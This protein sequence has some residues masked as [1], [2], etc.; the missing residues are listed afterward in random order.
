[1]SYFN[2]NSDSFILKSGE[3]DFLAIVQENFSHYDVYKSIDENYPDPPN[4]P[5]RDGLFGSKEIQDALDSACGRLAY[6]K[7][8]YE[9]KKEMFFEFIYYFSIIVKEMGKHGYSVGNPHIPKG[10][11]DEYEVYEV[12]RI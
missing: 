5:I 10:L 8:T 2:I 1:M 3:Y 12:T 4:N 9:E 6:R 7:G 11:L